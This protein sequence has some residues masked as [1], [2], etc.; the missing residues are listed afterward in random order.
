MELDV[1][2]YHPTTRHLVHIEPS[3][4]AHSWSTREQ[5]FEKKFSAARRY[6]FSDIFTWLEPDTPIEQIAVL[7]SHPRDRHELC[8]AAIISIDELVAKIRDDIAGGGIMAR[9]A[10]PEQYPQLRTIQ[11]LVA[12]YY[13]VHEGMT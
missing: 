9:N 6:V 10:I 1:I 11:L 12:G 4:D 13:R 2:G 5:R 7:I 8:G 3:L